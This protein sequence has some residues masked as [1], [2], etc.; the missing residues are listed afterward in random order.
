MLRR[1][2]VVSL[3]LLVGVIS[4]P[5]LCA[6]EITTDAERSWRELRSSQDVKR[7]LLA[8]RW[9]NVVRQQEWSDKT[10]KFKTSAKYV[11]HDPQLAWVK[12]RVIQG[13]GSKRVVKDVQIPL[14]KLSKS[15]QARVRQIA[16]LSERMA[17]ALEAEKKAK[18]EKKDGS[19]EVGRESTEESRG[20]VDELDGGRPGMDDARTLSEA[21]GELARESRP[22][23]A[24]EP[25]AMNTGPPL[26]AALPPLP[27]RNTSN[28]DRSASPPA[29]VE[30][31]SRHPSTVKELKAAYTKAFDAGDKAALEELIY[32]GELT[33]EQRDVTR[34]HLVDGAG[35]SRIVQIDLETLPEGELMEDYTFSSATLF[36]I[37]FEN[38]A[39]NRAF[40][41]PF[42]AIEGRY[43]LAAFVPKPSDGHR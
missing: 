26:P 42:M 1:S 40:R 2:L 4:S 31:G 38:E 8:N 33:P 25:P 14:E 22:M 10:G 37:E 18:E 16:T 29:D 17:A 32:W 13:T 5:L 11:A 7:K 34:M 27:A 15:C 23:E 28:V 20:G 21:R 3:F 12:L 24:A 30:S 9:H 41:W 39:T 35:K 43:Y 19:P 6:Q 36:R